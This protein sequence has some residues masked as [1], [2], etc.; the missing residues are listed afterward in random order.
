MKKVLNK[1]INGLMAWSEMLAEYR[2]SK[3]FKQYH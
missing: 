3:Y 1:I 2:Q